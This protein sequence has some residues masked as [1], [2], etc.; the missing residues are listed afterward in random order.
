MDEERT[1]LVVD[2]EQDVA[3]ALETGLRDQGYNIRQASRW[4]EAIAE[5]QDRRPDAV[6]LDLYLP[7]V[8]GEA[9]LEFIRD[10]DKNLPVVI[11]SSEI[12]PEKLEQLERKGANGFV[13]KP[14]SEDDLFLVVEQIL[15]DSHPFEF[16]SISAG[17]P[18]APPAQAEPEAL[19]ILPGAGVGPVE[20]DCP[21]VTAAP[22]RKSRSSSSRRK[23]SGM[24]RYL[25]AFVA[26]LIATW[27]LFFA[28]EMLSQ[29]FFGIDKSEKRKE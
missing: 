13:R 3:R 5:I 24:R 29:G 2:D 4:T 17:S 18:V 15:S 27:F 19:A 21:E 25:V 12:D 6:L 7:N 20:R 8:Q 10:L 22:A 28:Q 11:V 1:I 9:L 14:I 26:C 23:K 16:S